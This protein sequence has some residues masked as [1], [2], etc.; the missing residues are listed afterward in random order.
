MEGNY[1]LLNSNFNSTGCDSDD[2]LAGLVEKEKDD[3]E[4]HEI[5][6]TDIFRKVEKYIISRNIDE[7]LILGKNALGY[8]DD[9]EVYAVL[10]EDG[11]EIDDDEYF[12][13]L[14]ERTTL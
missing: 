3:G 1:R 2:D 8:S 10:E 9:E 11:T 4:G 14:P 5:I 7:L 13:L 6:V 12:Q